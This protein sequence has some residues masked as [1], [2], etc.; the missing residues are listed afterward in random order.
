M[1]SKVETKWNEGERALHRTLK[2]PRMEN[3]TAAGLPRRYHWRI[4]QSPLMALGTID[5]DG[6]PWTTVWGGERAFARPLAEDIIGINSGVSPHDPV[7]ETLWA[8]K[9]CETGTD[10]VVEMGRLMAGLAIDLETRDR[11]K[12]MGEA[13]A[14]AVTGDERVQ[15]AFH[16]TG[17][18]GNCPKYL[19][20]KEI[21][22]HDTH[23]SELV[24]A[25]GLRLG[26]EALALLGKADL[27]FMSTTDGESMDT[28]H[29]GGT[30]GFVRVFRNER[31]SL[32]LV[33]PEC[34]STNTHRHNC[35]Y[36][37]ANTV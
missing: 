30:P 18:L 4:M 23:G 15:M 10:D 26:N 2:V 14:G 12:L 27:F 17:S 9:G 11:V 21:V 19:N 24:S 5:D 33:Y 31:D 35:K 13:V 20:K 7:F 3:P 1:P 6:R 29:R 16:V 8:G 37:S 22:P 32:E 36:S 34:K 25:D 28:N